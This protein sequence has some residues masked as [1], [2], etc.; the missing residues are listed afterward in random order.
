M[1]KKSYFLLACILFF[2][3]FSMAQTLEKN[4]Q[5][6]S[7]QLN[8]LVKDDDKKLKVN[9]K[10]TAP[11]FN[12]KGCQ[13]NMDIDTKDKD[14][15]FQMRLSW[16]LKDVKGVTYTREKDGDYELN[17]NVPADKMKVKLG[18]G[19]ENSIGGSF[20]MKDEDKDDKTNFTLHT[21]DEN[22]VRQMV[23]KFEESVRVCKNSR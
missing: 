18:F 12:F 14:F 21:R 23:A 17:L 2:A 1:K 22:L 19:D 3:K 10:E 7:S 5:W 8:H 9:E 13:M 15:D 20:N 16:L 4:T 11:S 6:L